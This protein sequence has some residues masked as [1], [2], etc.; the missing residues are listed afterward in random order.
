MVEDEKNIRDLV[1][2]HLGHEGYRCEPVSDGKEAVRRI[3]Q[4]HYD[5]VVVD[6]MIPELDGLS[7]CRAIR[8]GRLNARVPIFILT[9]RAEESDKIVGLESGADDYLTKP[10]GV[11][12]FVARVRVLL[13]RYQM[14]DVGVGGQP[15]SGAVDVAQ[16]G[17]R[18]AMALI[19]VRGFE[20]DPA[21]HC[22]RVDGRTIDPTDQ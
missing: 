11:R 16:L 9:A 12:E 3:E 18:A 8:N 7:L 15:V 2:L 20:I 1:C 14:A 17:G 6:L 4:D 10:F 22:V 19:C 5:L 13:R 21:R